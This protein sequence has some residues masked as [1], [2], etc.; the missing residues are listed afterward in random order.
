MHQA[1]TRTT[2]G[3]NYTGVLQNCAK[4]LFVFVSV[5][6]PLC[7]SDVICKTDRPL[8]VIVNCLLLVKGLD[9]SN[10]RCQV[11]RA[12][13][14]EYAC[15]AVL[16]PNTIPMTHRLTH[17]ANSVIPLPW[18]LSKQWKRLVRR[19]TLCGCLWAQH[20]NSWHWKQ[21][22]WESI[23]II[24]PSN[25]DPCLFVLSNNVHVN[26]NVNM[27]WKWIAFLLWKCDT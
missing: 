1:I 3:V 17:H 14:L 20:E 5:S 16:A 27:L 13:H 22:H 26:C 8:V 25:G 12:H 10:V 21:S 23:Y 18:R 24:V 15:L 2:A 19:L 4:S 11:P 6:F 7:I 9:R